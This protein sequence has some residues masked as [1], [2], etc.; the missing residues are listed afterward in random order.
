[1]HASNGSEKNDSFS[2]PGGALTENP[3]VEPDLSTT[4]RRKFPSS[5]PIIGGQ[6]TAQCALPGPAPAPA[7]PDPAQ[8]V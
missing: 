3:T 6:V 5:A 4:I 8:H 2:H 1:V 7:W